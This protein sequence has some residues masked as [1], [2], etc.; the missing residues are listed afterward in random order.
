MGKLAKV[1][2]CLILRKSRTAGWQVL[3]K[4]GETLKFK[5]FYPTV[6]IQKILPNPENSRKSQRLFRETVKLSF[7]A[8]T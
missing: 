5:E 7:P 2:V 4:S 8:K 1:L 3:A 6:E